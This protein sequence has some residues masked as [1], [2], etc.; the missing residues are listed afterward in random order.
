MKVVE[1][2]LRVLVVDDDEDV[3]S[4]LV[5]GLSSYGHD[6]RGVC[7]AQEALLELAAFRPELAIID[8]SLGWT[9]GWALAEQIAKLGLT[10]PPKLI[11]LSGFADEHDRE[12]SLAAGFTAHLSKP[13]RIA[14]LDAYLRGRGP[15]PPDH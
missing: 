13:V 6:V 12:R 14:K 2:G 5:D 15:E 9:D 4:F 10:D 3:V 11:A 7:T 8:I 1:P